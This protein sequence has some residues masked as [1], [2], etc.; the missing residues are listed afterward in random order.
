MNDKAARNDLAESPRA[1]HVVPWLIG[2]AL[3]VA[4]LT[5]AA[6][7]ATYHQERNAE[8]ARIQAVA[9]VRA[10]QVSRWLRERENA[11][12]FLSSSQPIADYYRRCRDAGDRASLDR[13]LERLVEVRRSTG[14]QSVL[15]LD[16]NVSAVARESGIVAQPP[17][18]L[19][20]TVLRALATGKG[21]R[22]E[23]YGWIGRAPTPRLDIVVPLNG[24]GQPAQAAVVMRVDPEDFLFPELRSWPVPRRSGSS[25]L[26]RRVG[27]SVEIS[28]EGRRFPASS[29]ILSAQVLRGD[30]PPHVAVDSDDYLGVPVLGAVSPIEGSDWNLVAKVDL[31]EVRAAVLPQAALIASI[32]VL[33]FLVAALM[34]FAFRRRIELAH[35]LAER[36]EKLRA[37][38]VLDSIASGSTDAIIGKD[39]EGR[40]ISWN[41]GAEELFGYPADEILGHSITVLIPDDR[42]TEEDMILQAI[43]RGERVASLETLRRKKDGTQVAVSLNISPIRD[44]SGA[45]VGVSKIARDISARR[46][47]EARLRERES[48]LVRAQVMARL[49]HLITG[50]GGAIESWSDTLPG[51]L[52]IDPAAM[53]KSLR[54][55][56]TMVHAD[57]RERLR[58]GMAGAAAGGERAEFGYRAR[59]GDGQ[60]IHLR[61]EMQPLEGEPGVP[62]R[63]FGTLQDV[64]ERARTE[65]MLRE[66]AAF[67]QAVED[68]VLDHM[69]VLDRRGIIVSVNAAWNAFAR[70]NGID[71]PSLASRVGVGTD[72]LEVCHRAAATAVQAAAVATAIEAVIAG[73]RDR[74]G[75]EYDCHSPDRECW[76]MMEVT[77]LRTSAGGAVVVHSDISERKRGELELLRHRDHLEELVAA[78]SVDLLAA[79]RSLHDAEAFL[80]AVANNV[81]GRIA[82]WSRDGICRFVN[83]GYCEF[84][85]LTREAFVGRHENEI[86][87]EVRRTIRG[88]YVRAAL[89]GQAQHFEREE[90]R[91]DGALIHSWIHYIPHRQDATILGFFVMATDVTEIKTAQLRLQLLNQELTDARNR[92]EASTV[93]KSAFLANMSHEIRTPMNAII[94]LTHLLRR[95]TREPPQRERLGKVADAAH[96]LLGVINDILD[97]SKIESGKLKLEARDFRL[98]AML[99]R[100]CSLVADS[101]RSKGLE[102]VID[103]DAMPRLIRGDVT[104]LSQALLNLLGNAVKFTEQGSVTLRA[105]LLERRA[106]SMLVRFEV[107]DTGIGIEPDRIEGLFGAFEQADSS[108]TRRY[109]GTGL[110][111]SITR[112]LAGL[113][114]GE[115]GA[116]SV[117]GTGSTFWFSA[118]LAH[119][120]SGADP[121]LDPGVRGTRVL[122]VDDLAEAR[123]AQAEMLRRIGA[124]V[125]TASSGE[126]ALALADAARSAGEPYSICVLDWKMPGM[127]GIETWR[128]L[129][130]RSAD[131]AL[132]CVLV[133]A[134]DDDSLR[135]QAREQGIHAVLLKPVSMSTMVDTLSE[136]IARSTVPA[137][138]P[139]AGEAMAALLA[140]PVRS[141]V[142]L[143][144]D[145]PINREVAVELLRSAGLEV[146][147]A[148]DG[149]EAVAMAGAHDYELILMDVQMPKMDGM[150]ATRA[151]RDAP[152][153][154]TGPIIA[155]TAN[156]FDE[157]RGACLRAGMNDHIAKPVDPDLLY[158]T[159]LQWLP[160]VQVAAA[161]VPSGVAPLP[162]TEVLASGPVGP[163]QLG[164]LEGVAGLDVSFGMQLFD[165]NLEIYLRVI[166][167][168]ARTYAT[169][170][171]QLD[172]AIIAES[173]SELA[174]AGHSIRGASSSIGATAV[175]QSAARL[176]ALGKTGGEL[177]DLTTA[178]VALQAGLID[179]AGQILRVLAEPGDPLE[180]LLDASQAD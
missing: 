110:G 114:G 92:S 118:R 143:A 47:L 80:R 100:V 54:E 70:A 97:L 125:D 163:T 60:W 168:F 20:D 85:G 6:I 128:H 93:A 46:D 26:A 37:L 79:N 61:Q 16:D 15:V 162:E 137:R 109:G 48:G 91:I 35:E 17:D 172:H 14:F 131:A 10:S 12:S 133:T 99:E 49:G 121:G 24:T 72:Y 158:Q 30:T 68:S 76:F 11:A 83:D 179:T 41:R 74:F 56:L 86:L 153:H 119:P 75:F 18:E 8:A 112:Q 58:A 101:A 111:L 138:A 171:P 64:T 52:G 164:R 151:L 160:A 178:A 44:H 81:P 149:A 88:P 166:K 89:N 146:D 1:F 98:D 165:G 67:V 132:R 140:R 65:E 32:A 71:E 66:S 42:L 148:A 57:D 117:L 103:T 126:Q 95:D 63:W 59:R 152:V 5:A 27:D 78:R 104:R 177:S 134:H 69:A 19:R 96:H 13:M 115:A 107:R 102:L 116:H 113:M 50:P 22:T 180:P 7:V 141:R 62:R 3:A 136:V 40:V 170:S 23:L 156:A 2:I 174:A 105:E 135:Q 84:Y 39:L 106:D 122:L 176:E 4:A 36:A 43:R 157:D 33:A 82:Y 129:K 29:D 124:R 55:W 147:V 127:D 77:P 21:Q 108:T 87:S 161:F 9:D 53:P 175:E 150:Q 145:N 28:F 51:L 94:G 159:L 169:G 167:L 139:K 38:Q 45:V 130:S 154:R 142:L 90:K 31:G 120:L 155:M 73:T 34:L 25:L 144:E 173:T 123:E